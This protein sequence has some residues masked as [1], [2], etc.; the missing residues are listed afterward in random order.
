MTDQVNESEAKTQK[1]R[2]RPRKYYAV[3]LTI[4]AVFPLL[5]AVIAL[6]FGNE[7]VLYHGFQN[8]GWGVEQYFQL[9]FLEGEI[10]SFCCCSRVL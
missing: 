2:P 7:G 3:A 1:R 4:W 9:V 6:L 8:W 5:F 10:D